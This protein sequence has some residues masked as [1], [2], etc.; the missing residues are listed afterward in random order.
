MA[1]HAPC[2]VAQCTGVLLYFSICGPALFGGSVDERWE[3]LRLACYL[4]T[5]SDGFHA[6][7]E[8]GV[9]GG[10]GS[11]GVSA[12]CRGYWTPVSCCKLIT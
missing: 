6:C 11:C 4:S 5:Q 8:G 7:F 3:F 2:L 12:I 10:I 1:G 9:K